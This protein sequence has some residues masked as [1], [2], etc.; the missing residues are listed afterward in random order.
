MYYTS[1]AVILHTCVFAGPTRG[2]AEPQPPAGGLSVPGQSG[3]APP[4]AADQGPVSNASWLLDAQP[5]LP[6]AQT[7]V[8]YPEAPH[9]QSFWNHRLPQLWQETGLGFT[10]SSGFTSVLLSRGGNSLSTAH[11]DLLLLIAI[12]RE[13]RYI[14][15]FFTIINSCTYVYIRQLEIMVPHFRCVS[16][17]F[18]C[19]CR[20]TCA[21][22]LL[23]ILF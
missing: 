10:R 14:T 17:I 21:V 4:R 23:T 16:T 19:S 1:C 11:F 20:T 3:S 7:A 15:I 13:S 2:S 6:P 12:N 18:L 9:A 5:L 8:V 22:W